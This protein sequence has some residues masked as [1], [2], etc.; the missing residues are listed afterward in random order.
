MGTNNKIHLKSLC[1]GGENYSDME[2]FV[3]LMCQICVFYS[4][5]YDLYMCKHIIIRDRL[6]SYLTFALVV[7][8]LETTSQLTSCSVKLHSIRPNT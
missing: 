6:I 8:Y 3:E 2:T 7:E 5:I 1:I 4:N